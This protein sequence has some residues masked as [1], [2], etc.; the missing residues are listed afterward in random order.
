MGAKL[1]LSI[2]LALVGKMVA[3]AG[4]SDSPKQAVHGTLA[5]RTTPNA[6]ELRL[7]KDFRGADLHHMPREASGGWRFTQRDYPAFKATEWQ[8]RLRAPEGG[9][10]P[11]FEEVKSADFVAHF[12]S[13]SNVTL[14]WSKGS[15]DEPSDFQPREDSLADGRTLALE[16]FGGRS[17][18][19]VMPYSILP[20][21]EVV[22]WSR[23]DG[24]VIGGRHS[25]R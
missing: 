18:D 12:P 14:H 19:G 8:V 22:S 21:K 25:R 3:C 13:T 23:W 16:S 15:H 5:L 1:A 10:S 6:A 4:Q 17:S 7:S 20:P 2:T 11:L 24:R 9:E